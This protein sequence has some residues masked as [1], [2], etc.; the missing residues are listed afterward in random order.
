MK[1]ILILILLIINS[2][3]LFG[4]RGFYATDSSK[5]VGI[6]LID[7]GSIQNAKICKIQRGNEVIT[8]TPEQIK[9]Y[10]FEKGKTYMSKN[11]SINNEQEIV[12]LERLIQ[13]NV[14][15]YF[16]KDNKGK[17]FYIE[18]DSSRLIELL[19]KD[20]SNE[21]IPFKDTLKIIFKDCESLHYALKY[22]AFNNISLSK[23]VI[24]LNKCEPK[25]FPYKKL[26]I[27]TGLD[28]SRPLNSMISNELLQN[29]EFNNDYSVIFGLFIDLPILYSY[30]SIHPE[31]YFQKNAFSYHSESENKINDVIINASN[32]NLPILFRYTYPSLL[33]RP[34]LNIGSNFSFNYRNENAIYEANI[35]NDV[36]EINDVKES[37]FFSEIQIG[38]IIGGGIQYKINSKNSIF[39]ELRF[40]Q[41]FA[42]K[43]ETMGTGSFQIFTGINL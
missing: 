36:I 12:F 7:G 4:Q 21:T 26:G 2:I 27:I 9:E 30:Y 15:L 19:K 42:S 35:S 32:L 40:I 38:Y 22:V 43:K 23:S 39:L 37:I 8:Y 28:V 20:K 11:I 17:R 14:N 18:T 33:I 34:Y 24:F 25:P 13:G 16:Y 5:Y 1:K 10:G 6:K 31:I 29:A 3:Y 41:Q